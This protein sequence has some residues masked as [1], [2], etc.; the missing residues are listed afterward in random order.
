[1]QKK[2]AAYWLTT[3]GSGTLLKIFE[4]SKA[5]K[6]LSAALEDPDLA[7]NALGALAGIGTA[8]AQRRI[9]DVALTPQGDVALR[10]LA[11]NQLAYH[12]QRH[13]VLLSRERL[14]D[15]HESWKNTDKPSVKSALASVVGSLKPNATII[16]ERLQKFAVPTA[17]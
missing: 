7:V 11:A 15:V 12:I 13:G 9:A 1:M 5:E 16:G 8:S 10:E 6:E 3:I 17:N 2:A 4:I 14:I